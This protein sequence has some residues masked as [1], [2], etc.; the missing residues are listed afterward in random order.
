M[1]GKHGENSGRKKHSS[2]P[3]PRATWNP[4]R[5]ARHLAAEANFCVKLQCTSQPL[6]RLTRSPVSNLEGGKPG[7]VVKVLAFT[8]G[9]LS[10]APVGLKPHRLFYAGVPRLLRENRARAEN[11]QSR[12][13]S[14]SRLRNVAVNPSPPASPAA[15]TQHRDFARI[16]TRQ[17]AGHPRS[18][19]EHWVGA[20]ESSLARPFPPA[21]PGQR[22]GRPWG[23]DELPPGG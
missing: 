12:D 16:K 7:R 21:P 13:H 14:V 8:R 3:P 6:A 17:R 22:P 2:S 15:P 20:Q 11:C 19:A 9:P 1:Q 23:G 10:P 4:D 5:P 18:S